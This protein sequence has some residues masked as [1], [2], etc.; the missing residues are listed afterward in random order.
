MDY[1]S[2]VCSLI[3]D[4]VSDLDDVHCKD[5]EIGIYNWC[6]QECGTM[7][8]IRNWNNPKFLRM[9][10]EKTRSVLNNID[11]ESYINNAKLLERLKEKEFCPHDIAFMRPEN[12]CPEKWTAS[13]NALM[14]K[15]E[16]AYENKATAMTNMFKC[17][18][19]KKRECTFYELQSRSG[20]EGTTIFIRCVNCGNS[21][22]Q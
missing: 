6:I 2:K 13:V 18:K 3:K 21:W 16:S 15:Y 19:C 11:R 17:G 5:L 9:Y 7:R 22:R 10:I 1:R 20:D 8:I 14:K 4:K 12:V